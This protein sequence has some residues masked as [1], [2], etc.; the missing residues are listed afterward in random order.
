MAFGFE[1]YNQAG[2]Y[3]QYGTEDTYLY[4]GK[5]SITISNTTKTSTPIFNIPMSWNPLVFGIS[6]NTNTSTFA[7]HAAIISSGS[8]LELEYGSTGGVDHTLDLYVFV[9]A[10][11]VPIGSGDWGL[12]LYDTNGVPR[13]HSTRP[14]LRVLEIFEPDNSTYL[15]NSTLPAAGYATP[16]TP[17]GI[18]AQGGAPLGTII[19]LTWLAYANG[20]LKAATESTAAPANTAWYPQAAP[21]L[22]VIDTNYYDIYPSFGNV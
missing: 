7:K 5:F 21:R 6:S 13:F 10:Q 16:L 11:H 15:A 19:Y 2:Q 9:P 20:V 4:W 18:Q 1:I 12:A 3:V 22:P 14:L 8:I 17:R